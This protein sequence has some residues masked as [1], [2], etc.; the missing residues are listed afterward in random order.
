[1]KPKIEALMAVLVGISIALLLSYSA[2]SHSWYDNDC[3]HDQDCAPVIQPIE[4]DKD[5]NQ[6]MTTKHGTVTITPSFKQNRD[7]RDNQIHVCMRDVSKYDEFNFT[8]QSQFVPICVYYPA[9]G[10]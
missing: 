5:G 1:M 2:L 6:K 3:C 10:S 8:G 9:A 4:T 7:S